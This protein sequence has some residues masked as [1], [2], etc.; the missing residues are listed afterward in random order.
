MIT[1]DK[2]IVTYNELPMNS[3][4]FFLLD[5][6]QPQYIMAM[7]P[8][9]NNLDNTHSFPYHL[10]S[11]LKQHH[12][13]HPIQERLNYKLL[14]CSILFLHAIQLFSQIFKSYLYFEPTWKIFIEFEELQ[15]NLMLLWCQS[16]SKP[17]NWASLYEQ[18]LCE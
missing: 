13:L 16:C 9:Q 10:M 3:L 7:I 8:F 6:Q 18:I 12:V 15:H 1:Q 4:A 2:F 17:Y 5:L 14:C 11:V